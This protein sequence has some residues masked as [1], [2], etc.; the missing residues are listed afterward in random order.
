[1]TDSI[2]A[3]YPINQYHRGV[4]KNSLD[5]LKRFRPRGFSWRGWEVFIT[6]YVMKYEELGETS[7]V[8]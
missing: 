6:P 3:I 5:F 4:G 7:L 8:F 2:S 1:M